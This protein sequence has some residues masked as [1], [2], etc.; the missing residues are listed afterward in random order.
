MQVDVAYVF[1]NWSDCSWLHGAD[2]HFDIM[3][4][5][6]RYMITHFHYRMRGDVI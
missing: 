1:A 2:I 4:Q 3:K 6:Y 5:I